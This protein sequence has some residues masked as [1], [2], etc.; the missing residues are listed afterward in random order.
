MAK[1]EKDLKEALNKP[2]QINE[3]LEEQI[4]LAMDQHNRA[5]RD[6]FLSAISAGLEI[7][8]SVFLMGAVYTLFHDVLHPSLLHLLLSAA[9]PLGFVLV[10]LGRS[11]LFTEHTTLAVIPV[12]N[13][14]ASVKSLLIVWGLVY[15]GNLI[16]GYIFSYILSVL[17][18]GFEFIEHDTF[19]ILAQK[20][21]DNPLHI[22]IISGMLAGWLMGLLSWLVTS[23]QDT[24]SRIVII[25]LITSVIGFGGLH[26]SIVGSIEIFAG[27]LIS[28]D[29]TV[30]NYLTVQ[31]MATLGNIIGGVVFV[32]FIKYSHVNPRRK[33]LKKN[34]K[35]KKNKS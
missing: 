19:V 5:K 8:F 24:I 14:N 28:K 34:Q 2:K 32:A 12:L 13:K 17:P 10:I 23:S 4:E 35:N 7:G 16:G 3:I 22:I 30:T 9:Y 18:A 29:I 26:H 25:I 20:L 33:S 1:R 11:E 27:M 21:I 6:L 31:S 15:S